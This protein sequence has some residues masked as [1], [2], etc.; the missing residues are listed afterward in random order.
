METPAWD[1]RSAAVPL[2]ERKGC[3]FP[4]VNKIPEAPPP[5]EA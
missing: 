3:A 5:V 1:S 2:D 4:K